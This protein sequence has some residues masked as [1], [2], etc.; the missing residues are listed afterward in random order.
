MVN[1]LSL[2]TVLV[3]EKRN[4]VWM[5]D[6]GLGEFFQLRIPV[7]TFEVVPER[8]G[9]F[10]AAWTAVGGAVERDGVMAMGAKK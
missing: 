7:G 9:S 10:E 4:F 2:L 6:A 3:V 5:R 1:L 8:V